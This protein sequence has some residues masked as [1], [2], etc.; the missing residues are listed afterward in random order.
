MKHYFVVVVVV[1]S[2]ITIYKSLINFFFLQF[3]LEIMKAL[4]NEIVVQNVNHT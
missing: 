1:N 3:I 2:K 4:A